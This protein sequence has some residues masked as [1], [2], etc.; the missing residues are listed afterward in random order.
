MSKAAEDGFDF[1]DDGLARELAVK[2]EGR[3][4]YEA[5][6][7]QWVIWNG[8]KWERDRTLAVED[9]VRNHCAQRAKFC[10]HEGAAKSIRSKPK[11]LGVERLARSDQKLAVRIDQWDASPALLNT[12]LGV[13]D[14]ETCKMR[15][16]RPVDFMTKSTAVS[17]GGDCPRW[18]AFLLRITSGNQKLIGYLQRVAGY[19]LTG[20]VREH[21]I[22][23]I[24]GPGGNG[25][26]IFLN[27]LNGLMGNYGAVAAADTF[28]ASHNDKHPTSLA[29]L[30][31]A[32]FVSVSETEEGRSWAEA[33]L[34]ALSGGDPITAHYMRKDDFT[35]SPQFKL[36]I[37]SN[38][39]PTLRNV[40]DAMRRRLHLIEFGVS[41]PTEERD[42]LLPEKLK[43]E[44]GGILRWAI[45]GCREWQRIGLQPPAEIIAASEEYFEGQDTLGQWLDACAVL[46]PSYFTSSTTL[47]QSWCAWA[48][49]AGEHVGSQKALSTKLSDRGFKKSRL[50]S[51]RWGFIGITAS[52]PT[53]N[54]GY[55][56]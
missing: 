15:S 7:G 10:N 38:H 27:T 28:M 8:H 29:M 3:V 42:P 43:A 45:D 55:R 41:I 26:S 35:F 52:I 19:C 11:I 2:F 40:D 53:R 46:G 31:G 48:E 44:W 51:G 33:R 17:P 37:A 1:S 54:E 22:F 47:F 21:V 13:I 12:P 16:S 49:A 24:F 50:S 14:L 18:L 4:C 30:C 9:M 6:S 36:M 5:E 56:E 25:K 39:K 23:F 34:K 32:R 20:Y